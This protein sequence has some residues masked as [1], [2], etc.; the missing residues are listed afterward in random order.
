MNGPYF[1][2][3]DVTLYHGNVVD[4]LAALPD[5]AAQTVVTS[6]PY[7]G[8]RDYGVDGQ[9]GLESS[10]AEYVDAL[11]A[12]F[13][14]LRRVIRPDGTAWLNLGDSYSSGASNNGGYSAKS[15]LAGF[16]SPDT[17]G[18][19]AN[20]SL[21]PRKLAPDVPPKNLLGIPWRVAFALQDDGWILRNANVWHKP[22]AMPESVTDRLSCRY[23]TVFLF[24]RSRRYQF[25]LDQIREPLLHPDAADGSRVFGGSNKAASLDTGSSSR[26]TGS[27]YGQA[28]PW[29]NSGQGDDHEARNPRGRNPGDVWT[30]P[31]SPY[32]GAHFATM[33]PALARRCILPAAREGQTVLDPFTGSGTTGMVARQLGRHFIGID[34]NADYL[35]LAIQ[36][37][38]DPVID[39]G[40]GDAA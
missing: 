35:N 8:L 13:D 14:Q 22:N 38:G 20:D 18:R 3:H 21:Q 1:T 24:A 37:I 16:T 27:V 28:R 4:M 40:D 11:R 9:I 23:E 30:I 32:P 36:R 2:D 25:D 19:S 33:P 6:P 5:G 31:T 17:K 34:L 12:V 26:R 7:Y 39:F 29:A 10:P 15:T